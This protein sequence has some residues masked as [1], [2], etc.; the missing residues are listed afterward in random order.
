MNSEAQKRANR[1]YKARL[2]ATAKAE[3]NLNDPQPHTP[4]AASRRWASGLSQDVGT[5]CSRCGGLGHDKQSHY[6]RHQ[7]RSHM[8]D[9][10]EVRRR[11]EALTRFP[12]V[13]DDPGPWRTIAFEQI[14]ELEVPTTRPTLHDAAQQIAFLKRSRTI[15]QASK[16]KE[17]DLLTYRPNLRVLRPAEPVTSDITF[18]GSGFEHILQFD[19]PAFRDVNDPAEETIHDAVL[20]EDVEN[21]CAA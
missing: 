17:R 3:R 21:C 7:F 19:D 2:R 18:T 1:A 4:S 6:D 15:K 14:G 8:F 11:A 5:R 10:S 20:P 13:Q 9:M 12:E 16:P